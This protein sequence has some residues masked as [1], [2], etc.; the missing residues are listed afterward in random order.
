[1]L[2]S[3]WFP[4]FGFWMVSILRLISNFPAFSPGNQGSFQAHYYICYHRHYFHFLRVLY[5]SFSWWSFIGVGVAISLHKSLNIQTEINNA[6]VGKM[7]ILLISVS[8]S[9]IPNPVWTFPNA[10]TIFGIFVTF[11][12]HSYFN[13]LVRFKNLWSFSLFSVVR[14]NCK[15]HLITSFLLFRFID[16][17]VGQVLIGWLFLTQ[18]PYFLRR[19]LV[20]AYTVW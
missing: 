9:L 6:I 13:S 14:L 7:S 19:V 4:F 15:S 8:T 12:F 18:N 2:A 3:E 11:V 10:P 1:M 5:I 20:C 16:T 17:W